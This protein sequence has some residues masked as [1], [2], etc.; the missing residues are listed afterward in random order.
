MNV[1]A[2]PDFQSGF[3]R[4]SSEFD[5]PLGGFNESQWLSQATD[6]SGMPLYPRSCSC[7]RSHAVTGKLLQQSSGC[8]HDALSM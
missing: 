6:F 4:L 2:D 1:F 3:G 5:Y 8:I 7:S